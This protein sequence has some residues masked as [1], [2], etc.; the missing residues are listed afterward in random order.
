MALRDY[1]ALLSALRCAHREL[2]AITE[3]F[4]LTSAEADQLAS[5]RHECLQLASVTDAMLEAFD[6]PDDD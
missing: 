5:L 1:T 6:P 3:E 4:N 2:A